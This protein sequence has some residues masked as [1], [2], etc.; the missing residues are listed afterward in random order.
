M[1]IRPRRLHSTGI[2]V[3]LGLV[4]WVIAVG[5][6]QLGLWQSIDA[7]LYDWTLRASES[8]PTDPRVV[9]VY[10]GDTDIE[11][12]EAEFGRWP[13]DSRVLHADVAQVI[14]DGGARVLGYDILFTE[15][16]RDGREPRDDRES[17]GE[18]ERE[19]GP[20]SDDD[21]AEALALA[22][23]VVHGS[24]FWTGRAGPRGTVPL[25][26]HQT[27]ALDFV[28]ADFGT[29]PASLEAVEDAWG[30]DLPI[31]KLLGATQTFGHL[32][33]TPDHDFAIRRA[34]LFV[35]YEGRLYP[36]LS[37]QMFLAAHGLGPQAVRLDTDDH[38]VTIDLADD[39]VL[40]VPVDPD[41]TLWVHY[42][43]PKEEVPAVLYSQVLDAAEMGL[44]EDALVVIGV[45]VSASTDTWRTPM[46]QRHQGFMIHVQIVENLLTRRFVRAVQPD[47]YPFGGREVPVHVLVFVGSLVLGWSAT[48]VGPGLGWPIALFVA[49]VP[50]IAA[51]LGLMHGDVWVTP[52]TSLTALLLAGGLGAGYRQATDLLERARTRRVYERY[53]SP[54]VLDAVLRDPELLQLGGARKELSVF[55]SDIR[56]FTAYSETV[57]PVELTE[58][59]NEYYIE[60]IDLAHREGATIDKLIGDCL[61]AFWNDPLDQHDHALR[62]VR[63]AWATQ[64]RLTELARVWRERGVEVFEVGIG[65]E[66]GEMAVGNLGSEGFVD[67]TVMGG[68]VNLAARLC[69]AA[70][71]G[72]ILIGPN[73][74]AAV[75]CEFE[76][77][78]IGMR[79]FKGIQ[80]AREVFRVV[81]CRSS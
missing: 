59:L 3:L 33:A 68:T 48:R 22:P 78:S 63:T 42:D 31:K 66:C 80:G 72:E 41:G 79:S 19:E 53:L 32:N 34:P 39:D 43:R 62:A 21:L 1:K 55:F 6:G 13:W 37:L 36:S 18:D 12:F 44:F 7:A 74:N 64:Q 29:E 35:R 69:S 60:M 73:A 24:L 45:S 14:S 5:A 38:V 23:A 49:A 4:G 27:E 75:Q 70:E 67:Y 58:R 16:A 61:M 15:S 56:G 52:T 9:G 10:V 2:G 47:R 50:P 26:S 57:E 8:H 65:I 30:V 81:G 25:E 11:E 17:D 76:T 46:N 71:P 51:V 54:A 77:E 28:G 20:S 40:E